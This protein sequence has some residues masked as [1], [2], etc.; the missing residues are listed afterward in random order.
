MLGLMPSCICSQLKF[1]HP[2][3]S[4]IRIWMKSNNITRSPTHMLQCGNASDEPKSWVVEHIGFRIGPKTVT[5]L[6]LSNIWLEKM[7]K[8]K[9]Y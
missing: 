3:L 8:L 9:G 1:L 6:K 7:F 4:E 5:S 2:S